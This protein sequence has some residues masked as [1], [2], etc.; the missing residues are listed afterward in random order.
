MLDAL[1]VHVV[2]SVFGIASALK[3]GGREN[4]NDILGG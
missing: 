2:E 3:C 4:K 1:E